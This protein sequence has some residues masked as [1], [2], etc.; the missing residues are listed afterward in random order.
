MRNLKRRQQSRS[1]T[2]RVGGIS[3][4]IAVLKNFGIEPEELLTDAGI[5][6]NSLNDPG[7]LITYAARDRLLKNCVARTGCQHFGLQVGG[8]MDL[9]SLGLV[10][11]LMKTSL[12]VG[13]ALRGLVSFFHLHAQGAIVA[14]RIEDDLAYLTYNVTEQGLYAADQTGD[15]AVAMMLNI[16]RTLCGPEF[17]PVEAMFAHRTPVDIAPFRKLFKAPLNF[18]AETY[19]L[20]FSSDWLG[21]RPPAADADINHLLEAQVNS[22]AMTC[23]P[24]FP[25]Q[26]RRVL[27]SALLTGHPSEEQIARLFSMS[28]RTFSRRLRDYDCGYQ[29]LVEEV[30]CNIAQQL[31]ISTLL[32]VADISTSLGYSRASTFIRS[33]R[34]WTGSTPAQW[35]AEQAIDSRAQG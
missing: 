3:E 6:P 17:R 33:F 23:S 11:L 21:A 16:M 35:R 7:N 4:I 10:G 25:E 15:G 20:V 22:Q 1:A 28:A 13:T 32:S 9:L 34:R 2:L 5:D 29:K 26:V 18:N 31:L 12:T 8:R 30:R 14:L 27:Y 24:E 19:S